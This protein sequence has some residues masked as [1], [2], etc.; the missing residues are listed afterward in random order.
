MDEGAEFDRYA[1]SY[2]EIHAR[3]LAPG[4]E[5]PAYYAAYKQG[6]VERILGRGFSLPILDYGCGVGALTS[7]LSRSFRTVHGYDPSAESLRVARERARDARFFER[8]Q[9]LPRGEYGAVILANVL[10]HVAPADR[11][12][13]LGEVTA[14]LR[15]GGALIAFEHNRLNPVTRTIVAACPFDEGARLLHSGE[16]IRL[17]R[18]AGLRSIRRDY[19]VF[20]P[21]PLR[22][23]RPLEPML[24][25]LPLG[26]QICV[27][28]IRQ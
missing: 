4:G 24:R 15:S 23:L 6:I 1:R 19:I 9:A 18:G 17:L 26:A 20:F 21:R 13:F 11:P 14:L 27:R 10:H 2:D 12:A 8:P 22:L 7:L 28:G 3:N 5:P 25:W 16:L